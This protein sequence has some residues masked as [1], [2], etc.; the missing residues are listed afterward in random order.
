MQM[1]SEP[2]KQSGGDTG[3]P[4]AFIQSREVTNKVPGGSQVLGSGWKQEARGKATFLV[5]T[6]EAETTSTGCG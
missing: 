3:P 2:W 5:G 1:R 6:K 4:G